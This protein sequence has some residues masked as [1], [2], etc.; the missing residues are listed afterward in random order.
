MKLDI[1]VLFADIFG[2]NKLEARAE[3]IWKDLSWKADGK[4]YQYGLRILQIKGKDLMK[5]KQ[6]LAGGLQ[7]E[8]AMTPH[9]WISFEPAVLEQR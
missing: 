5:L 9:G 1:A 2:L 7:I 8:E 3:V 4:G 6:L